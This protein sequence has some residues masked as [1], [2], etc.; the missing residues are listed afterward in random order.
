MNETKT[1]EAHPDQVLSG[2]HSDGTLGVT[3]PSP[4]AAAQA[5][6]QVHVPVTAHTRR[7]TVRAIA[8]R[9]SQAARPVAAGMPPLGTPLLR[10]DQ[11]PGKFTEG[12]PLDPRVHPLCRPFQVV[13]A[14][15]GLLVD[16]AGRKKLAIVGFSSSTRMDAPYEDPTWA[17]VGLNQLY[18]FIPRHDLWFEIHHR[19]MFTSDIVR[20]TDYVGWLQRSVVPIIMQATQPDMPLS[21]RFP[22]EQAI[23]YVGRDYFESSI[24]FMLIWA[25]LQGYEEVGIWG[26]DLIIGQ[27]YE[28]Q[29]P[30]LEYLLGLVQ[31]RG[32]KVYIPPQSALLKGRTIWQRYG[33]PELKL[34]PFT[35]RFFDRIIKNGQQKRDKIENDLHET[36]GA[37]IALQN[38]RDALMIYERG[39]EI[40]LD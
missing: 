8:S 2:Y 37:L 39:G 29:K 21:V 34:G 4:S 1:N 22:Q 15:R 25:A 31:A 10:P 38:M 23:E 13:D 35:T 36:E 40:K 26:V 30:N 28:Y 11:D 33:T 12:G 14:E 20:D 17:I 7:R 6:E 3:Q 9:R 5:P 19:E 18:R 16:P 24:A 27:E 32:M